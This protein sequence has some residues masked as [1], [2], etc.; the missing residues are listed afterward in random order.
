MD[1][2][3]IYGPPGVG[4]L[5]VAMELAALTGFKLFHNHLSIDCVLPVFGFGDG[6]FWELVHTIRLQVIEAAAREDVNLI[7][8]NVYEHPTDLP[9]VNE[10]FA[11]VESHGGRVCPV[12]I[13]CA[14]EELESRITEDSHPLRYA[15]RG[16]ADCG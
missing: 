1:L 5:T 14:L 6:P 8:T 10:R 7:F 15:R 16:Q 2:V 11:A 12:Q 3:F 4:K 13:I 9:Q